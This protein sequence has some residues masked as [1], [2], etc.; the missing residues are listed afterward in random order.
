MASQGTAFWRVAGLNFIQYQLVAAQTLRGALK[1]S[2]KT[3]A[4]KQRDLVHYRLRQWNKGTR[5]DTITVD[6]VLGKAAKA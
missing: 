4:V 5:S 6:N 3:P 1:E 2:V